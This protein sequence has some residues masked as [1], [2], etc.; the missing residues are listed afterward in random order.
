MP[1]YLKQTNSNDATKQ[2]KGDQRK[3][4]E[5][6]QI[7]VNPLVP[8]LFLHT[9]ILKEGRR[10]GG[11]EWEREGE[12]GQGGLIKVMLMTGTQ[13]RNPS[14]KKGRDW[15]NIPSSHGLPAVPTN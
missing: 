8:L 10:D 3:A 12:E 2:M 6:R 14:D 15:S 5:R 13:E 1:N 9:H 4:T 7:T 11:R